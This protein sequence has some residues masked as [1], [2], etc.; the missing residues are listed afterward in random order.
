[1]LVANKKMKLYGVLNAL[2]KKS[3]WTSD[4]DED[5]WPWTKTMRTTF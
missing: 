3:D 1:M 4:E 2:V 5:S